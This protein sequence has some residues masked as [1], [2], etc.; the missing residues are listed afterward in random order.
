MG[1]S[2]VALLAAV[3]LTS[4]IHHSTVSWYDDSGATAS[5]WHATYGVADCGSGGGPCYRMGT[6]VQ[7]CHRGCVVAT[8]DDHG[9][10]VSGREWDLGATTAQAIGFSCGVCRVRWRLYRPQSPG[11]TLIFHKARHRPRS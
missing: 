2:A 3:S 9:P 11:A 1:A 10:Y 4:P 6:K 8:V 5:G 7:F